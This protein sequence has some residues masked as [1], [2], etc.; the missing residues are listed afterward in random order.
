[1]TVGEG[2]VLCLGELVWDVFSDRSRLGGA[3]FNVAVHLA[4]QGAP[5]ALLTAVGRDELGDASLAFLEAEGIP[6]ALRHP[7]L[8][9]GTVQVELGLGGVPCF[10]I[11]DRCAW[12]DLA[13][14]RTGG[15]PWLPATFAPSVV[16]FGGLAMHS[17]GNRRAL[18]DILREMA[19]RGMPSPTRVCD[20]NLRPG[21][22]DPEVARWCAEQADIL[23]VNEEELRFLAIQERQQEPDPRR[24]LLDRFTLQGLCVTRGPEGLSWMDPHGE[25]FALPTWEEEESPVVDTVGAG[26]AITASLALGLV[27]QEAPAVFLDRG[28]R[29]AA[30]VCGIPGALPERGRAWKP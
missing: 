6:G 15:A 26:D 3:P 22:S 30:R 25:D 23:K 7:R 8:P 16:V 12:T 27:R 24:V 11:D 9:T 1:M 20:L 19:S 17:P 5:V 14:G 28:R 29:W 4:R 2:A 18:A 21:W 13:G 10:A